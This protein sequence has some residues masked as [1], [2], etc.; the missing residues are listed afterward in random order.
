MQLHRREFLALL[1]AAAAPSL[2]QAQTPRW[3]QRLVRI[4]LPFGPGSG[5]DITARMFADPLATRWGKAVIVENRPGGDSIVAINALINANDDHTILYTAVGSFTVHPYMHDKLTYTPA[6]LVP[7]VKIAETMVSF[8]VPEMLKV[9]SLK[10]LMALVRAQ[11]DKFNYAT[12]AGISEFVLAAY[13][14]KAGLDVTAVPY[15][16]ITKAPN[17][18]G[19]GRIQLLATSLAMGQIA[20]QSGKSKIIA[21]ANRL[22]SPAAPDVPTVAESGFPELAFDAPTGLFGQRGMPSDVRER[23]ATDLR[24]VMAG[25]PIIG[26]RME[27]IG[28]VVDLEGPDQFAAAIESQR[29]RVA[30]VAATLGMKAK[31]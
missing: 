31:Q 14:K 10:E 19:E 24:A 7:I 13:F 22:R 6:D 20:A 5:L 3:P 30:E 26:S 17:D 11:P 27:T 28:Q 12:A 9:G 16:D 8:S 29:A 18:L 4:I 25:N 2:A 21:V 15:R 23:I 1:S